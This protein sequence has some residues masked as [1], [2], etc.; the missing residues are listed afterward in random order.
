M[1][2]I[3]YT[4]KDYI[5]IAYLQGQLVGLLEIRNQLQKEINKREEELKKLKNE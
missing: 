5:D 1:K 4:P 3:N 2:N